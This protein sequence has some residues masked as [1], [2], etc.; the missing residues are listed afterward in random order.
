MI[1]LS[2]P[3]G[4]GKSDVALALAQYLPIE[5]IN[6]DVGQFYVPLTIGTA[7]P[8][9]KNSPVPH[10]LFDIIDAPKNITVIDFLA[11]VRLCI[12]EIYAR[13]NIPV[14]VGG[15]G[16]YLFSLFFPPVA[17]DTEKTS[18]YS[19]EQLSTQQLWDQLYNLDIDRAKFISKQDRYRIM[20]A[21]DLWYAH[22][23][24]PSTFKPVFAP[25]FTPALFFVIN[26]DRHD[27]YERINARVNFMLSAGWLEEVANLS[28]AWHIFLLEKKLIGYDDII[29][30]ITAEPKTNTLDQLA[31][32]IAQKTRA[33]AKRQI[34]FNRMITKKLE[35]QKDS[36]YTEW[37]NVINVID[38]TSVIGVNSSLNI[39]LNYDYDYV[40][41]YLCEIIKA[42]EFGKG[43]G[44]VE[45]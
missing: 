13:G 37:V 29:R 43:F 2:G 25:L 22:G 14:L 41:R 42:K 32:C 15:T 27:L 6:V 12:R 36:V 40:A 17:L 21:L 34:T 19:Y 1:I 18:K 45:Q 28:S 20:R 23:R 11:R 24:K 38:A 30:F 35:E 7:K 26:R 9:W 8:D 39:G 5:I 10:H 16:F 44:N 31:A 4:V 3:T 33:Y